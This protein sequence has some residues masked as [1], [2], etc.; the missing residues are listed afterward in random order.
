VPENYSA[1]TSPMYKHSDF[2]WAEMLADL[3]ALIE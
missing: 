2:G 1:V 3:K